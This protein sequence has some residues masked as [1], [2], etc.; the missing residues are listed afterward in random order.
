[1]D[2]IKKI[3]AAFQEMGT[4]TNMKNEAIKEEAGT[5]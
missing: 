3:D 4:D 1:M 2:S 5:G